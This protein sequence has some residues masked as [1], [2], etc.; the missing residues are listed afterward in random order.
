MVVSWNQKK[1][2]PGV[3]VGDAKA[4]PVVI[5]FLGDAL[6]A[7]EKAV[8]FGARTPQASGQQGGSQAILE[9][10]VTRARIKFWVRDGLFEF[11]QLLLP[12]TV[13]W[14]NLSLRQHLKGVD[15]QRL[16]S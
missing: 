12:F 7:Y 11:I 9:K 10:L 15:V 6:G 8:H 14:T 4:L 13:G 16:D 2:R 1:I 3:V 5:R